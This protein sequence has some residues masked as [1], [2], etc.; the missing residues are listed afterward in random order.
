MGKKIVWTVHNFKPHEM[1]DDLGRRISCKLLYT[2]LH[3]IVDKCIVLNKATVNSLVKR[4][5]SSNDISIIAHP[6]YPTKM[7]KTFI[8]NRM[9]FFGYIR[10]YKN[11]E[12]L[13]EQFN[14]LEPSKSSVSDHTLCLLGK[15]DEE[16]ILKVFDEQKSNPL[17][18]IYNKSYSEQELDEQLSLAQGVIVPYRNINNSGVIIKALSAGIPLL[19][20]NIPS[21]DEL[22]VM[23][24]SHP[25]Y[26]YENDLDVNDLIDFSVFSCQERQKNDKPAIEQFNESVSSSHA[27]LY[28]Q[29]ITRASPN[30]RLM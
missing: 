21:I 1:K 16:E 6:L 30:A 9:L 12:L 19:V 4:G 24:P 10:K 3:R 11:V 20:P 7:E 2:L 18:E 27:Q 26:T 14:R 28:A 8:N 17:I 22:K 15:C 5:I 23:F 25:F 29:L 13:L